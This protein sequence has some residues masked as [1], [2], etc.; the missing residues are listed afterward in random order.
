[1]QINALQSIVGNREV[2]SELFP[3]Q[4][5]PELN[6]GKFDKQYYGKCN[7]S[8]IETVSHNVRNVLSVG[9]AWG[10]TEA[11]LVQRGIR[12]VGIPLDLVI[13]E[14]AKSRGIEVVCPSFDG[15][16]KALKDERF[17]YILFDSVLHHLPDPCKVLTEY[18][19]L[20]RDDG[21]MVVTVPNFRY[22]RYAIELSKNKRLRGIRNDFFK[23]HLHFASLTAVNKWFSQSG[24][25]VVNVNYVINDRFKRLVSVFGGLLDQYFSPEVLF[26]V[27][28][29]S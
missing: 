7:D 9:C 4:T 8:I 20:L 25:M 24:L 23:T 16:M 17:D 18:K 21:H 10:G 15:A 12:V 27:K 2:Q 6:I 14:S 22:L 26:V 5:I 28:R 29:K 19:A 1:L 13:A 11:Q 3:T